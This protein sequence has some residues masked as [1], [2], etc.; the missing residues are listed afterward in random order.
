MQLVCFWHEKGLSASR[1]WLVCLAAR[2]G[3]SWNRTMMPC[4]HRGKDAYRP[5]FVTGPASKPFE[6][7]IKWFRFGH[8]LS[9]GARPQLNMFKMIRRMFYSKVLPVSCEE[10]KSF[11]SPGREE[12]DFFPDLFTFTL[13]VLEAAVYH[14][15]YSGKSTCM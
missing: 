1:C 11:F 13:E 5:G 3:H 8:E 10:G 6:I 7:C 12:A 15:L 14:G 4:H 9:T 2:G